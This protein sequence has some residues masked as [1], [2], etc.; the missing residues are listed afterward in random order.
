MCNTFSQT[1]NW[2]VCCACQVCKIMLQK[3]HGARPLWK[4]QLFVCGIYLHE[5]DDIWVNFIPM[6]WQSILIC[7]MCSWKTRLFAICMDD[8]VSQKMVTCFVWWTP[9]SC[10]RNNNHWTSQTALESARYFSS[11]DDRET[12]CW[13]LLFQ[14][15]IV[16]LR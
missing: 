8:L 14:E 3:D 12:M 7:L 6:M 5:I 9:R 1:S 4:Y 2:N 13:F 10:S 16:L 11:N 15:M